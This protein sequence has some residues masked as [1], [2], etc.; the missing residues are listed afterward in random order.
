MVEKIDI[1]IVDDHA[2]VR[3]GLKM[4]LDSVEDLHL[5]GEASNAQNGIRM[6]HELNPNV[7]LM[8]LIMPGMDG[9]EAI[10]IILT[11][12]PRIR[13]IAL[14]SFKEDELVFA[15][16]KAGAVSYLPKD[17]TYDELCQAIRDAYYGKVTVSP[18]VAQALMRM[19]DRQPVQQ[20]HLSTREL[21]VLRLVVQGQSNPQIAVALNLGESTIKFHVSNHLSKLGVT[22]RTEAAALAVHHKL[23]D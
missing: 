12:N 15:A 6:S 3:G 18:E 17:V 11:D 16:L 10:K 4:F 21:D 22:S 19:A 2:I 14:T 9:V 20:Y 8:D 7:V 13:V 5:V 1:L 23:V